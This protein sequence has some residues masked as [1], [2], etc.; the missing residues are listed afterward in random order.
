MR[1]CKWELQEFPEHEFG[2]REGVLVHLAAGEPLH[3]AGGSLFAP[4]GL[5]TDLDQGV[6]EELVAEPES[7]EDPEP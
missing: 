1:L 5:E 7:L 4:G 2:S 3:T 6:L